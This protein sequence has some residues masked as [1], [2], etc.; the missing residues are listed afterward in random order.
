MLFHQLLAIIIYSGWH[1]GK[2]YSDQK[3]GYITLRQSTV[4]ISLILLMSYLLFA[5][6]MLFFA[7]TFA[8][9]VFDIFM[10]VISPDPSYL[11]IKNKEN[12]FD[13]MIAMTCCVV[14]LLG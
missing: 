14:Y 6:T 11:H 5:N 10:I 12:L 13:A 1:Y 3:Q 7:I 2:V 9:F 4:K 8:K